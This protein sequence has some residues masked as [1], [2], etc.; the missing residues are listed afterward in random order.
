MRSGENLMVKII[1]VGTSEIKYKKMDN[2]NGPIFA[3]LKSDL[4]YIKYENGIKEDY[5]SIPKVE[6][7]PD[8]FV[9]GQNDAIIYYQGYKTASTGTL[10]TTALP[11]YGLFFGMIPAGMCATAAPLDEN[12]GY[13]DINLMKNEQYAAGYKQKAK[14]IKSSKVI[15]NYLS[16]A[17]VQAGYFIA[18]ML[19]LALTTTH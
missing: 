7:N 8:M 16:G 5:S 11:G 14:Q 17:K 12:L 9:K 18:F 3:I 1:E 19:A 6:K 13:P 15:K 2:L 10:V 4:L